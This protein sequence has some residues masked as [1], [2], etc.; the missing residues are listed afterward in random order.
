[1]TEFIRHSGV[2]AALLSANIDTDAIIPSSEMK[3]VSKDGLAE[4]FFANWRYTDVAARIPNP[5][6][7]LNQPEYAGATIL[8]ALENFGCGSSREFAV[9]ALAQYGIRVVIA[10]SFGAIFQKNCTENNVLTAVVPEQDV[11]AIAAWVAENPAVNHLSVDLDAKTVIWA[12]KQAWFE[13][14]ESDRL[15]VRSGRDSIESTMALL[16]D[17]EAFEK[18]HFARQPWLKL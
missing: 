3:K 16:P 5:S 6:F 11:R 4:S 15:K 18:R 1:M 17:I 14:S 8:L 12:D 9:W 7:V 10:P 2:T 13:I